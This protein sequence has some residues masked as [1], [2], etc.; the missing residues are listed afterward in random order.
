VDLISIP[1][2]L[3][4]SG[5]RKGLRTGNEPMLY[6]KVEDRGRIE[7]PVYTGMVLFVKMPCKHTRILR[8]TEETPVC[9]VREILLCCGTRACYC[10]MSPIQLTSEQGRLTTII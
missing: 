10:G 2:G 5:E 4:P 3:V 8:V 6:P 7:R 1:L 9:T